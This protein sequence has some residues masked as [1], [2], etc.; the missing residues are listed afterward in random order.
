MKSDGMK[1][2]KEFGKSNW[3]VSP[4]GWHQKNVNGFITKNEFTLKEEKRLIFKS[5][6]L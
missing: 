2:N 1:K 6:S 3:H 5:V 4:E